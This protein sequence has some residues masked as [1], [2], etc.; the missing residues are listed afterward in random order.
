MILW[1]TITRGGRNNPKIDSKHTNIGIGT[2]RH[3]HVVKVKL[4]ITLILWSSVLLV[5]LFRIS[6]M[7]V[8]HQI[9][10]N[11]LVLPI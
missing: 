8:T 1:F 6:K 3:N 2:D 10:H 4:Q 11:T 9:S 5:D 7:T